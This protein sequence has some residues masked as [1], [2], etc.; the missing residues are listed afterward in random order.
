MSPP[1]QIPLAPIYVVDILGAGLMI[2]LSAMCVAMTRGLRRKD[3][4]NLL[5]TYLLWLSAGLL[6]FSLSRSG[7]HL[8]KYLLLAL[9]LDQVWIQIRPVTGSLNS[10]S[11]VLVGAITLFFSQIYSTYQRMGQDKALIHK[12]HREILELN[13]NLERMVEERT[14]E[15][16]ASEEKYRRLFEG[17][18]DMVFI[19][20]GSGRLLDINQAGAQLLGV[21]DRQELL[22][23]E[24][25]SQF[26]PTDNQGLLLERLQQRD[27]VMDLEVSLHRLGGE[28][29]VG[30]LAATVRRGPAGIPER[31][32][33]ILKD[34]SS[35]RWMERQLLQADKL[36]SLGQLSAGVAHEINNPL[37]L[38]LGYTQLLLR[39][40][41]SQSPIAQDLRVIEKHAVHCKRIVEDLLKFSRSSGTTKTRQDLNALLKEVLAVVRSKFELERVEVVELLTPDLPPVTVDGDKLKQ[42]FMNLLMNARQAISGPGKIEVQT[43]LE[44]K[45]KRILVCFQDTGCGIPPEIQHRIFDPFFTT[46]PVGVGTGLGLSVSYGIVRDHEG[47]IRVETSLGKG[48][49]FTV[50]LPLDAEG[51]GR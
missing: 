47:E 19:C 17:S 26:H 40:L 46:K 50:E 6:V 33:G 42:V 39:D 38:I 43:V 23:Q 31:I 21:E 29:A 27:F 41:D 35:R 28:D 9:Q 4:E 5:W 16:S 10:L 15:L 36:A 1:T 24:L 45:R 14:R 11:F 30:L 2:L 8:V 22:G 7:S 49:T 51:N 20:D 18:R 12:A 3:P 32:E 48:S 25:L 34:I 37:G 44:K 13:A